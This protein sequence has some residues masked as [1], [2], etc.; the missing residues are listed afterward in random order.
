VKRQ[1]V[2]RSLPVVW[3]F[4]CLVAPAPGRSLLDEILVYDYA[5]DLRVV[6]DLDQMALMQVESNLPSGEVTVRLQDT[7]PAGTLLPLALE[8]ARFV[9]VID[10][11]ASVAEPLVVRIRVGEPLVRA[12]H[13]ALRQVSD[14]V[15]DL[16][17]LPASPE[18]I[19]PSPSDDY[20]P[21]TIDHRRTTAVGAPNVPPDHVLVASLT[22]PASA[23]PETEAPEGNRTAQVLAHLAMLGPTLP[24]Q[25]GDGVALPSVRPDSLGRAAL[26]DQYETTPPELERL[27]SD[28]AAE[29]RGN[30]QNGRRQANID[31]LNRYL[32]AHPGSGAEVEQ[33]LY[34]IAEQRHWLAREDQ[35]GEGQSLWLDA[36]NDFRLALRVAPDSKWAPLAWLR[37]CDSYR[38]MGWDGEALAALESFQRAHTGYS[39]GTIF[40]MRARLLDEMGRHGEELEVLKQQLAL[41]PEG[42]GIGE[43]LVR[44]GLLQEERGEHLEA[45]NAFHAAWEM[46]PMLL[47]GDPDHLIVAIQVATE[48]EDL[49]WAEEMINRLLMAYPEDQ[50]DIR[51]ATLLGTIYRERGETD[52]AL[53]IY[54]EILLRE[55]ERPE[56]LEAMIR[57][58]DQGRAD[59]AAGT[60][61]EDIDNPAYRNPR[62]AYQHIVETW[63]DEE[64]TQVAYLRLGE[65]LVEEGRDL[66]ALQ[67]LSQLLRERPDTAVRPNVERLLTR[68]LGRAMESALASGEAMEAVSIH[69]LAVEDGIDALLSDKHRWGLAQACGQLG[70][71][72]QA[73]DLTGALLAKWDSAAPSASR[74][75]TVESRSSNQR[76]NESTSQRISE[77][78]ALPWENVLSAHVGALRHL[79]RLDE[80]LATIDR[81][82]AAF[83]EGARR[84]D[85]TFARAEVLHELNRHEEALTTAEEALALGGTQAQRQTALFLRAD[86][87]KRTLGSDLAIPLYIEALQQYQ[88]W[89]RH[90]LTADLPY[91]ILFQLADCFYQTA[92]WDRARRVYDEM[93]TAFPD[94]PEISVLRFRLAHCLAN[95]GQ[96]EQ[97]RAQLAQISGQ[98]APTLW[99]NLAAQTETDLGWLEHYP[100][101]FAQGGV[102]P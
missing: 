47:E 100:D 27:P 53:L 23:T 73:A 41:D 57:L 90:H 11:G 43:A 38:R 68:A 89:G 86:A 78:P 9:E 12:D 94:A 21:S 92:N 81:C 50:N 36:I 102:I 14:L 35:S 65:M 66:E 74:E 25:P 5:P 79:R 84:T 61:R 7:H 95:A 70:F 80:A 10:P 20:R 63:P 54:R 33:L 55:G 26:A 62:W 67:Q 19:A 49:D 93:I 24:G 83:P 16:A 75:S 39:A 71:W 48:N 3:A 91:E 45:Y 82:L 99:Q 1:R 69:C 56:T 51:V 88:K 29:Y 77:S 40:L 60:L 15:L 98:D 6:L 34:L 42:P 31:L 85:L 37:I 101:L 52:I 76:V 22:H 4:A 72:D 17:R 87:T 30:L 8:A 13:F 97:A 46:D 58:A 32:A 2:F 44:L 18:P 59:A 96:F 64:I 28:L